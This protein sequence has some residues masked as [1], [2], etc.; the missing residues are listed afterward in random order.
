M[1][2]DPKKSDEINVAAE[3]GLVGAFIVSEV[4]RDV[5]LET[6]KPEMMVSE[7]AKIVWKH[8]GLMYL[9]NEPI[10][11]FEVGQRLKRFGDLEKVGGLDWLVKIVES[12]PDVDHASRY[13]A[14]V[15]DID[16]RRRGYRELMDIAKAFQ[17]PD[18]AEFDRDRHM[19]RL[20]ELMSNTDG[21][22]SPLHIGEIVMDAMDHTQEAPIAEVGIGEL[23][24]NI[25]FFK[26][27]E[28]TILAARPG[29]GK[30]SFMRQMVWNASA[31]G[32]V[33]V[34]SLEVTPKV[35][36]QQ[37]TCELARVPF[38]TWRKGTANSEDMKA[39]MIAAAEVASRPIFI[40]PRSSVSVLD[41]SLS[42]TQMI[43][44]GERPVF[45]AVDYLGL[46]KHE[47]TERNDLSI[48]ATTRS[49]KCLAIDKKIPITVLCQLNRDSEKRG[50]AQ[51]CDRPRLADLRD[52]GNIEQ[53]ADNIAFIWRKN[54]SD[55]EKA[56]VVERILSVAK[57]RNGS[58]FEMDLMF[59]MPH[60]RFC[61]QSKYAT[62]VDEMGGRP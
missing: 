14:M 26:P 10:G 52:S 31:R 53:D 54:R 47:K 55:Y 25:D 27:G 37:L 58:T 59:D 9:A 6:A 56:V 57:H 41:I 18:S 7:A 62:P 24:R 46:M 44:R 45:V 42:I 40:F 3:L 12:C 39:V 30:S 8:L 50:T 29:G 11:L 15:K 61:Q 51:D 22:G 60:G 19:N 13:A 32:P 43:A 17:A 34:F 4:E 48:G 28:L 35:I 49:L 36:A 2:V 33:L 23:D 38:E 16:F 21:H 1:R 20:M 5:A